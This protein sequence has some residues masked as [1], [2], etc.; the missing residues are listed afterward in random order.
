MTAA[1]RTN[2]HLA[3]DCRLTVKGLG[4]QTGTLGRGIVGRITGSNSV[5]VVGVWLN[6]GIAVRGVV[7]RAY[8]AAVAVDN[9]AGDSIIIGAG[10][11]G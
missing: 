10:I 11:P 1:S 9:V 8:L 3:L 4:S 2:V 6:R 7:A 5:G